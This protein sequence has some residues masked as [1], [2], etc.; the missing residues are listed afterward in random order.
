MSLTI[1]RIGVS[2]A[3]GGD[4]LSFDGP[5]NVSREGSTLT[6]TGFVYGLARPAAAWRAGQILGLRGFDESVVPVTFSEAPELDG[7][8]RVLDASCDFVMIGSAT[9][10]ALV[11]WTVTLE[12]G[13]AS[14]QPRVEL[15]T[16][17]SLM[18][19]NGGATTCDVVVAVPG[20]TVDVDPVFT[21]D[22]S[23]SRSVAEGSS[24]V[25]VADTSTTAAQTNGYSTFTVPPASYYHGS[26][27][28][29]H[30]IG[31]ST[32]RH[33]MGRPDLPSAGPSS[34]SAVL[35][36][37]NGLVRLVLTY[38]NAT[39]SDLSVQWWDGTQWDT[40]TEFYVEG[41]TTH[42][43]LTYHSVEVLH[44]TA[45]Y[46]AVRLRAIPASTAVGATHVDV[47]LRR[48]SRWLSV[49]PT[50]TAAP[51]GGWRLGF[52]ASTA[53]TTLANGLRRTSN[54]A[55]GNR[56]ILFNRG[57][58]TKDLTNGR[59]TDAALLTAP[60][61]IGCEI[62]GS[63]ATGQNTAA[64]QLDEFLGVVTETAQIVGN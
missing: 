32:F 17:Y 6:V 9:Q 24:V 27:K 18:I 43:E 12:E 38:S 1:G 7:F 45:E 57:S 64:N 4:G 63:S 10:D 51:S 21:A 47:S 42:G 46:G 20:P 5:V 55:G 37:G 34:E 49:I 28:I 26:V 58:H 23:G 8:Y 54:N 22:T 3:N 33:A 14:R 59:L 44:N 53:S 56:E 48:G 30:D 41:V 36:L 50:S 19:N 29:E 39:V 62:A 35:R 16:V 11:P 31:S 25:Y 13:A 2:V 40:A 15:Y 60:F 61:G 52:T